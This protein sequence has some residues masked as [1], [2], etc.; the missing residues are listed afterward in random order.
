MMALWIRPL[1]T[2]L[3]ANLVFI[4]IVI[5][6]PYNNTK[7]EA[8]MIS[9]DNCY[10]E[11]LLGIR[12]TITTVRDAMIILNEHE[13]VGE[14]RQVAPGSGYGQITWQWSGQ[15]PSLIDASREGRLTFY[16]ESDITRNLYLPDVLIET[17]NIYTTMRIYSLQA[18]YGEAETGSASFRPNG[19]LGYSVIYDNP[20]GLTNLY[21]EL[22]CPIR[23]LDFWEARTRLTLSI[24]RTNTPFVN[25]ADLETLCSDS[26]IEMSHATIHV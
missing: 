13:W 10:G 14:V 20:Y 1:I 16:W 22:P 18:F 6:K 8:F 9:E 17:V 11:C 2:L 24:G 3:I 12:P 4:C 21:V 26:T 25:L 5:Y 19:V 15:Q 7:I 23:I